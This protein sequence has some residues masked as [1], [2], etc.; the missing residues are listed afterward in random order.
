MDLRDIREVVSNEATNSPSFSIKDRKRSTGEKENMDS[1][2]RTGKPLHYKE[3]R[4]E[5]PLVPVLIF[6]KNNVII[7]FKI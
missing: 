7:L 5:V 3:G 6:H 2:C 1:C 4:R